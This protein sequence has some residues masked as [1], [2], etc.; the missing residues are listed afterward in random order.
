MDPSRGYQMLWSLILIRF[1]RYEAIPLVIASPAFS[2]RSVEDKSGISSTC[3]HN[4]CH[5]YITNVT[6]SSRENWARETGV[7]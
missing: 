4:K 2:Q 1:Q 7:S 5:A 3:L 6:F